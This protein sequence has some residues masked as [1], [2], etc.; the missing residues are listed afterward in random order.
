M[1]VIAPIGKRSK[2]QFKPWDIVTDSWAR[3]Y[4]PESSPRM[5]VLELSQQTTYARVYTIYEPATTARVQDREM[6]IPNSKIENPYV[7]R[8]CDQLIRVCEINK[9]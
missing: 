6:L 3:D 4:P 5:I 1:E 9:V 7:I 2:L 8:S